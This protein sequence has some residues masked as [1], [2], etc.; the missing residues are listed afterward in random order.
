MDKKTLIN[1]NPEKLTT[2]LKS[3]TQDSNIS[4]SNPDKSEFLYSILEQKFE[5]DHVI[6]KDRSVMFNNLLAEAHSIENQQTLLTVLLSPNSQLN[7]LLQIKQDLK[8]KRKEIDDKL[9]QEVSVVIYYAAISSAL[10]FHNG[11]RISSFSYMEIKGSLEKII[12]QDWIGMEIS[13]LLSKA[14]SICDEMQ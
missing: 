5:F 8:K 7:Q 4:N 6:H 14:I 10:V 11:T 12:S 1:V 13:D 2:F 3:C 9:F